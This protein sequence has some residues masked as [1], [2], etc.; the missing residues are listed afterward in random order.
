MKHLLHFRLLSVVMFAGFACNVAAEDKTVSTYDELKAAI[1]QA[2]EGDVITVNGT[3]TF[4][5]KIEIKGKKGLTIK[6]STQD[7]TFDGDNKT[8]LFNLSSNS[9][10]TF[11]N[12]VI[13]NAYYGGEKNKNGAAIYTNGGKL[14]IEDCDFLNNKI[15]VAQLE[16]YEG[17]AAVYGENVTFSAI[18]TNFEGNIGYYGGAVYLKNANS[19]FNGCIFTGN[20]AGTEECSATDGRGGAVYVR[21]ENASTYKTNILNCRFNDNFALHYG[22]AVYFNTGGG[23]ATTDYENNKLTVQGCSFVGNSTMTETEKGTTGGALEL[24]VEKAVTAD[25]M[26]CT[27]ANNVA[28]DNGGAINISSDAAAGHMVRVNVVNCTVTGNSLTEGGGGNGG[29]ISIRHKPYN[30]SD[31]LTELSFVNCIVSG[32]TGKDGFESDFR[33]EAADNRYKGIKLLR[34]CIFGAI[35]ENKIKLADSGIEQK[36]V[37]VGQTGNMA[38]E[39]LLADA[40]VDNSYFP[41]K[42]DGYAVTCGWDDVDAAAKEYGLETDQLGQQL[43]R[44]LIGAVSLM[45]GDE[46]STGIEEVA[47]SKTADDSYYTISGVRVSKPSQPGIYIHKGKKIL[48]R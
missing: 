47:A 17:G 20:K 35:D 25:V 29:G 45:E 37:V 18:G 30:G 10:V 4:T 7:A 19:T 40:I 27:F 15:D 13:T 42:R 28:R 11:R 43:N 44:N 34:N 26:A 39:N 48:I 36:N 8:Q 46:I 2:V 5:D 24:A 6:G 32:N 21:T 22:G 9:E 33:I 14:V 3:V 41:L 16:S 38:T 31:L 23:G 12:L 1:E